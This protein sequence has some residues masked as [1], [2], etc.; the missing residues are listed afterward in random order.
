MKRYETYIAEYFKG[1]HV[2]ISFVM[3]RL[4]IKLGVE[5]KKRGIS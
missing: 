5:V 4:S 2:K 1:N 3:T